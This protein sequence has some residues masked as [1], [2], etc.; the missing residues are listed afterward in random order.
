MPSEPNAGCPGTAEGAL[1]ARFSRLLSQPSAGR[2]LDRTATDRLSS[3]LLR[4]IG[5][6][7]L[8]AGDDDGGKLRRRLE[9]GAWLRKEK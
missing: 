3:H 8:S 9:R 1:W 6:T 7:S 2:T 5:L 4:D